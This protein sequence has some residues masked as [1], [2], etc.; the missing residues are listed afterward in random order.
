M[1]CTVEDDLDRY[2]SQDNLISLDEEK[3]KEEAKIRALKLTVS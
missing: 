1:S 3:Q 2:L